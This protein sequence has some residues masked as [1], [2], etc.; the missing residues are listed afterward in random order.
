M[1][2]IIIATH[3]SM[4]ESMKNTVKMF[5]NQTDHIHTICLDEQGINTFETKAEA[6]IKKVCKEPVLV[7]CDIGFATPFN[8]FAK[9]IE[10][11]KNDIEIIAGVN[12]PALLEAVILQETAA[13]TDIVVN[14]KQTI[15]AV[16]FKE[17]LNS[18][19]SSE[20]E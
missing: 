3:G 17:Q 19:E 9:H 7:L 6:L 11:F 15:Q 5:C 16:S 13:V 10:D 18:A 8:V 2:E 20:D 1:Y 14:L 4:A 12:L